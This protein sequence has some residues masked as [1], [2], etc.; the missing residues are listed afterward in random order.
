[1]LSPGA[2]ALNR[3]EALEVLAQLLVAPRE[4]REL[5]RQLG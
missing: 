2:S 1:M 5:Q 4:V 3:D